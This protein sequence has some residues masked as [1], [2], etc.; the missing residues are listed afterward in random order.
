MG[1]LIMALDIFL[2][3]KEHQ[4]EK[5][6]ERI[7][8]IARANGFK[9]AIYRGRNVA[10]KEFVRKVLHRRAVQIAYCG[11]AFLIVGFLCL[12]FHHGLE[13]GEASRKNIENQQRQDIRTLRQ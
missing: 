11:A 3:E 6:L 4:L 1:A 13:I 12:S 10:E 7:S 8:A 2:R 9:S 5:K